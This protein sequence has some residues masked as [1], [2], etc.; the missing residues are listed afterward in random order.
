MKNDIQVPNLKIIAEQKNNSSEVKRKVQIQDDLVK[1]KNKG[2]LP[3]IEKK[4]S[5]SQTN[6]NPPSSKK[7]APV[8]G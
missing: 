6:T 4:E 3:K 2:T 7:A 5:S 1:I 8:K